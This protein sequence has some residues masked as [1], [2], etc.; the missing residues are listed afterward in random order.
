MDIMMGLWVQ[1]TVL[2]SLIVV[3]YSSERS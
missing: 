1:Y 2:P 3:F